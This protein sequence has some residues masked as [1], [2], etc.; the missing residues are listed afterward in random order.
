MAEAVRVFTTESPRIRKIE[1]DRPWHWLAAG[2]RDLCRAPLVSLGCGV[3]FAAV[4]YGI[5]LGLWLADMIYLVLP[6]VCGF[7][8]VGPLMAVGLYE[9][10]RRLEAGEPVTLTAALL[11]WRRNASQIGLM[12][13]ALMLFLFAWLRLAALLF[14][15]FYGLAPPSLETLVAD[16]FLSPEGLPFL[17]T[18][19]IIGAVLSALVYA[20]SVV[21]VPLLLDRPDANVITAIATS[22]VAVRENLVPLAFWAVLI[23]GFAAAGL[24]TLYLGLIVTLPLIG[25]ATW[26]AYRDLVDHPD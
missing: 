15:L 23:V 11:A 6:M 4:G 20:I 22:V 21:S 17:I 5:T 2:W 18:G 7:I 19:T 14:M 26:H 12:G 3:I 25:H 9:V 16:T 10:S 1:L 24:V 13:I 8:I